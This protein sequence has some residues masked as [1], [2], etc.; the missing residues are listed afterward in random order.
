MPATTI[1]NAQSFGTSTNV[2]NGKFAPA[3]TALQ[4][5]TSAFNVVLKIVLGSGQPNSQ[6]TKVRVWYATNSAS[7]TAALVP[8]QL[9]QQASY[10]DIVC[11]RHTAYAE[12]L[13]EA[14]GGS[15]FYCWV[16]APTLTVAS[17]SPSSSTNSHEQD[18]TKPHRPRGESV[19]GWDTLRGQRADD[20]R[21]LLR[22][23]GYRS[24]RH[25]PIHHPHA[26]GDGAD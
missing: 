20:H 9:G 26:V 13:T 7:I 21:Q 12:S 1:I 4:A 16:D 14:I 24:Q 25:Q 15:N 23:V 8:E 18:E 11:D 3:A 6:T 5:A 2:G 22:R 10:V 19:A 17:P